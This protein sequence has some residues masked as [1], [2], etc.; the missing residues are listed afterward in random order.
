MTVI[1][2]VSALSAL[3][4]G[5]GQVPREDFPA[6]DIFSLSLLLEGAGQSA[7]WRPDWPLDLPPDAFKAREISRVLIKMD[8]FSLEFRRGLDGLIEKFP[9]ML[10]N[11]LVQVSFVRRQNSEIDKIILGFPS[12]EAAWNLE[13]LE[14]QDSF[15]VLIRASRDGF[16]YFIVLSRG[17]TE[18]KESWYDEEGNFLGAYRV[19][20][21]EI[22]YERKAGVV[23]DFSRPAEDTAHHY[24]SRGLLT[25]TAGPRGVYRALYYRDDLPKYWERLPTE[26]EG[27][28]NFSLQW[29][30]GEF[31]VRIVGEEA[32][33]YRY[34]YTLDERGNWIERRETRMISA[35]GLRVPAQG[36]T[37]KR[38][39]EYAE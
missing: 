28:G 19:S 39:L 26:G 6:N 20:L 37:F 30:E 33:D 18:I 5:G 31:L 8:D 21:V 36:R 9:Y 13:V 27:A 14:H 34:E 17:V 12:G 10:N 22:G 35:L 3:G 32:E 1:F 38:V 7:L 25:E 16:W 4:E 23:R 24:D 15:P 11:S 29:D 2:L